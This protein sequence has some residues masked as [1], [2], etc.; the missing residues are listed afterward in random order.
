MFTCGQGCRLLHAEQHVADRQ[1]RHRQADWAYT[2]GYTLTGDPNGQDLGNFSALS[3]YTTF[4][5]V[6]FSSRGTPN[7]GKKNNTVIANVGLTRAPGDSDMQIPD[8]IHWR[9]PASICA[10]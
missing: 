2:S 4:T 5:T 8:L 10:V 9:W 6:S 1:R 3:I 7:D